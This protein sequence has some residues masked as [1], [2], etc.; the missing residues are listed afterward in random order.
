MA[1]IRPFQVNNGLEVN[2][3]A[4][5]ANALSASD[6]IQNNPER[7][8][9]PTVVFDF[10][11]T[12][13]L[14]PRVTFTRASNA[15]Y[16]AANTLI[17]TANNNIPRF[18]YENGVCQGLFI[19]L[20]RTN[21]YKYSTD[22]FTAVDSVRMPGSY[23]FF[24]GSVGIRQTGLGTVANIDYAQSIYI[25]INSQS[26]QTFLL[27]IGDGVGITYN[28]NALSVGVWTRLTNIARQGVSGDF[29][30]LRING[31]K[32]GLSSNIVWGSSSAS[33]IA[34]Q[35]YGIAPNGKI[36]STRISWA[37]TD[38]TTF[39]V[40]LWGFQV[41][42]G[43][44]G[45]SSY[46]TS[47]IPTGASSAT[48]IH[49]QAFVNNANNVL[50]L[51]SSQ[52]AFLFVGKTYKTYSANTPSFD[53]GTAALVL[54][55]SDYGTQN[56]YFNPVT[57]SEV[58]NTLYCGHTG[59]A[60]NNAFVGTSISAG[61]NF[62]Y[63]NNEV[64]AVGSYVYTDAVKQYNVAG[65]S[66]GVFVASSSQNF[67]TTLAPPIFPDRYLVF[68]QNYAQNNRMWNG[69]IKKVAYFNRALSNNEVLSLT[70]I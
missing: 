21:L 25:K 41:E 18:Q 35:N 38:N 28:A 57:L 3:N 15:T 20:Q 59:I 26:N 34:T 48:R 64:R 14:D 49:D 50:S 10:A 4:N 44:G 47:F 2:L 42:A 61:A 53:Q 5:V 66:N 37:C 45:G 32:L 27:D 43:V 7:A 65:S 24:D 9:A 54:Q 40:E 23:M 1:T 22:I 31:T 51:N 52:G 67:V 55:N 69:P 56:N 68:G 13:R 36:E 12:E 8:Y 30:D 19:E 29:F 17:A 60:P 39:D 6:F 46:I 62:L 33:G 11:K 58:T 63:P 70:T 16:T